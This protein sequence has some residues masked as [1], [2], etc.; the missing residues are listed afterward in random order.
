[1]T[2]DERVHKQAEILVFGNRPFGWELHVHTLPVDIPSTLQTFGLPGRM[3]VVQGLTGKVFQNGTD[4]KSFG[5]SVS[6]FRQLSVTLRHLTM[7][8]CSHQYALPT[9]SA[10]FTLLFPVSKCSVEIF[11]LLRMTAQPFSSRIDVLKGPN[12]NLED[13]NVICLQWMV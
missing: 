10:L 3:K 13:D 5:V 7:E 2:K 11:L 4:L 1:V 9:S 12:A 8:K 6:S